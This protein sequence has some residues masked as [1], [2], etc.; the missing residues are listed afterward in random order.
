MHFLEVEFLHI[1][2]DQKARGTSLSNATDFRES[3]IGCTREILFQEGDTSIDILPFL[4]ND[5]RGKAHVMMV[6]HCETEVEEA[7]KKASLI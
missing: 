1:V 2:G 3:S 6:S 5:E 7:E 4:K